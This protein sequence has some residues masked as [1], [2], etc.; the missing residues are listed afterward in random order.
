M[1]FRF[2]LSVSALIAVAAA[3][4]APNRSAFIQP[5]FLNGVVINKLSEASFEVQMLGGASVTDASGSYTI[6]DLFAV[7]RIADNDT[8]VSTGGT[9]NG[10][11]DFEANFSGPGGVAG[12]ATKP[13]QS[14][15]QPGDSKLR[16]DYATV[17]GTGNRYGAHLRLSNGYTKYY[18]IPASPVPEPSTMAVVAGALA[19]LARRRRK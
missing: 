11:W 16:F 5:S 1:R 19:I 15:L 8:Y 2:I 17:T 12:W 4:A 3:S 9:Q 18:E 6:T 14:G 10:T 13:P 7:Y